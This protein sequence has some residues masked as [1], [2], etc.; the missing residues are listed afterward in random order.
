MKFINYLKSIDGVSIYP[1]LTLL[2]FV[3]IFVLAVFLVY[4]KSKKTIDE[5]KQLPLED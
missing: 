5:I 3:T 2:I 1:I 4:S